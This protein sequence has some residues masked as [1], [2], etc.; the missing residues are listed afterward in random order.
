MAE[1]TETRVT[2]RL[3]G[4]GDAEAIHAGLLMI[5]RHVNEESKVTSTVEDIRRHGFGLRPAFEVLIAEVALPVGG[6]TPLCHFVTSPPQ[7]GRSGARGGPQPI[8]PLEG[9]LPDRAVGGEASSEEWKKSTKIFAGMCLFFPSFSTWRGQR[10]AYIQD[11]VVDERFRD[12]GIGISLL[13]HTAAHVRE[14]GGTYLRLSVDAKNVSAQR[15]YERLG[16]SWSQEERIHAAYGDAFQL[17]AGLGE[18]GV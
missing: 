8:S 12:R 3:A 6:N 11:I 15:F 5:A 14:Q 1:E 18:S 13:R 7:G 9:E 4:E 16:L 2:V 10:G 17:L